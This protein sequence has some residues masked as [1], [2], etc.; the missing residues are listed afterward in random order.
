MRTGQSLPPGVAPLATRAQIHGALH[1][2]M[3]H[4]L[5]RAILH[6][7]HQGVEEMQV[8]PEALRRGMLYEVLS[9]EHGVGVHL[10]GLLEAAMAEAPPPEVDPELATE[11]GDNV[12]LAAHMLATGREA[13]Y[14]AALLD[15][16]VL[17]APSHRLLVLLRGGAGV[18]EAM[19]QIEEEEED[20][21]EEEEE[22]EDEEE[23][24][25]DEEEEPC[26][27][28]MCTQWPRLDRLYREEPPAGLAM[29]VARPWSVLPPH[30]DC[31][32]LPGKKKSSRQSQS[33]LPLEEAGPL[34]QR[35]G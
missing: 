13:E 22:E 24:E 16:S 17:V 6:Q 3:A 19:E 35:L 11:L 18:A 7:A 26:R 30:R 1:T 23:E 27:C 25:E 2:L 34:F 29:V 33:L 12:L 14:R 8:D 9:E 10:G 20:E 28:D 15:P 4:A 32:T 21:E 31:P 5:M